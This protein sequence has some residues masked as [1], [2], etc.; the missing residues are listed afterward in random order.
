MLNSWIKHE[1]IA[2]FYGMDS[3]VCLVDHCFYGMDSTVC[4]V[5]HCSILSDQRMVIGLRAFLVITDS[6]EKK[7]GEPPMPLNACPPPSGGPTR[8]KTKYLS[9]TITDATAKKIGI[10]KVY[11]Q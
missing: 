7:E 8:V 1:L 9:T 3:T 10:T 5:D 2:C 11:P 4:L 6:L